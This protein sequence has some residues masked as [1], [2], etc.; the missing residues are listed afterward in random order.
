M[1]DANIVT[2]TPASYSRVLSSEAE[3]ARYVGRS[4]TKSFGGATLL[5]DAT[6][7]FE[8]GEIHSIVGENGA[9]KSTL[10]KI[11]AGI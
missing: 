5:R 1:I 8:P 2:G 7:A 9:G 6:V 4:I 10:V 11:L 3:G